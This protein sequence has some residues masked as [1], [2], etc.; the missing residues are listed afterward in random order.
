LGCALPDWRIYSDSAS[1]VRSLNHNL[2]LNRLPSVDGRLLST[3]S[4]YSA[5]SVI[6]IRIPKSRDQL[7]YWL[8]QL[9]DTSPEAEVVLTGMAKH[10]PVALLKWLEEHSGD[11]EQLPIVRKARAIRLGRWQSPPLSEWL[12]YELSD[13]LR[14]EALP[15]VF[16]RSQ[17]DIGARLFLEFL[18]SQTLQGPLLDLGCGNGVLSVAIKKAN[19]DIDVYAI[20][21]SAAAV[22]S[23]EVNAS[24]LGMNISASQ[25]DSLTEAAPSFSSILCNPPFHDG[26]LQLT[27]TAQRMFE[28]S[29]DHLLPGGRLYVIANRHLPYQ[30]L[31]KKSFRNIQV[32]LAGAKFVVYVCER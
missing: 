13:G 3:L 2:S 17:L 26:H 16:C 27:N 11:Y 9:A 25:S 1:A 10:I 14:V 4:D 32:K 23:T 6:V 29:R 24:R 22:K 5:S 28:D 12:G 18:A 19:P 31:L 7:H 21:D 30:A 15:G 8:N 20:D